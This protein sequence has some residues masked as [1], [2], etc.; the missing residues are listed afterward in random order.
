MTVCPFCGHT[1]V[2]VPRFPWDPG[3]RPSFAGRAADVGKPRV[4]LGGRRYV[5][6]GR[7]GVGDSTDVFLAHRDCALT[8]RVVI[9]VLAV[10]DDEWL[11]RREPAVLRHLAASRRQGAEHFGRLCPQLVASGALRLDGDARPYAVITRWRS[12]FSYSLADVQR[13]FPD[14]LDARTLVW[15]W[16]RVLELLGWVHRTGRVHGAV[17]PTHV[18]IHPR[19]HGATLIGWAASVRVGRTLLAIREADR[20]LYPAGLLAGAPAEGAHDQQML[21]RTIR[22]L[23]GAALPRPLA[24]LLR[25]SAAGDTADAWA[26]EREVRAAAREAFG[27]PRYHRFDMPAS[28]GRRGKGR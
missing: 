27:P 7:I 1:V 14:G 3:P 17:L 24:R 21:A 18:L 8:E 10:P 4:A 2:G 28:F 25:R 23:G 13:A 19:D 9:K 6:D 26:L 22:A 11:V 20:A 15:I 12:G 5:L 16:K